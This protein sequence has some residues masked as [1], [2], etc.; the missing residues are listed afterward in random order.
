MGYTG[1]E[2]VQQ[3]KNSRNYPK[4]NKFSDSLIIYQWTFTSKG[5][6]ASFK[7]R[8]VNNDRQRTANLNGDTALPRSHCSEFFPEKPTCSIKKGSE[9]EI[10][11]L[12][13][14]CRIN[15][16]FMVLSHYKF[17]GQSLRS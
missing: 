11:M 10:T 5:R 16:P 9:N 17:S 13:W 3:L 2:K 1:G 7:E 14:S 6:L 12:M 15:S 4:K 8:Y